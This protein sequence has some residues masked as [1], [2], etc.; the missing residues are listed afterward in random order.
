MAKRKEQTINKH[1][2]QKDYHVHLI[3][4]HQSKYASH[5]YNSVQKW[6]LCNLEQFFTAF[7]CHGVNMSMWCSVFTAC[8]LVCVALTGAELSLFPLDRT[9]LPR[10]SS[11]SVVMFPAAL[12]VFS[13]TALQ[14]ITTL[15]L[16][17][18]IAMWSCMRENMR[19]VH[20]VAS[21]NALL[22]TCF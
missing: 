19:R 10:T 11:P 2:H 15:A 3:I 6:A 21:L 1:E 8:L 14:S 17:L 5:S 18:L 13:V 16:V 20:S 22:Y 9:I 7:Q 12:M 4:S